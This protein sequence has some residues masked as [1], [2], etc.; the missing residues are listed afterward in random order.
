MTVDFFTPIVDD[1]GT[2]GAIAVANALSDVYAM[3]GEPFAALNVVAFPAKSQELPLSVLGEILQGGAEKAA[4]AGVVILGGHTIDDAEPKYGLAVMGR[5]HP[6]AVVRK[7]GIEPGDR[8]V[9]TKPIG[10]GILTTALKKGRLREEDLEEAVATMATLNRDASLGAIELGARAMT[11]VT[12]YGLL[13]HLSEM[14]RGG[15]AGALLH[16]SRV[17][18]LAGARDLAA[19]GVA[20]GG[21]RKNLDGVAGILSCADGVSETDRILLADAQTSGGLLVALPPDRAER[22]VERL[23]AAGGLATSVIGEITDSPGIRIET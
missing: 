2:Y 14:L 1:P 5:I 19:A 21:T 3:G 20:P 12:G 15:P 17:P 8:L 22:L 6:D 11:D 13:G 4:E 16:A 9:L 7:T 10:T 23:R 18:L